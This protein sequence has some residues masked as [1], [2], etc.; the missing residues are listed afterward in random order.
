MLHL[1]PQDSVEKYV[2][3]VDVCAVRLG[4]S[5]ILPKYMMYVLN[6]PRT[7]TAIEAL[8][9][10]STRKRI[11]RGNLSRVEIPLAPQN[12][13]QRIVSK[14]EE[15]F[16][17][18]DK[19][20]ESLKTARTKLNVY[21]QAVLKHAFEGKLTA[22]WREENKDKLEKPEQL[23]AR[24]KQER[25]A[26]YELQRKEWAAAVKKWEESGGLERKPSSPRPPSFPEP[27]TDI[28]LMKQKLCRRYS[29]SGAGSRLA[30]FSPF[31]S[32]RLPAERIGVIGMERSIG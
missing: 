23:L 13:Q 6:S 8:K 9:S 18:L 20:V 32:E 29:V 22:Q 19:G 11:S 4:T 26:R 27:F 15:L 14:I 2:T 25:E 21:R 31:T 16:S 28:E 10:G 12:E 1:S 30:N 24:I 3:V 7:R 17:E 5:S